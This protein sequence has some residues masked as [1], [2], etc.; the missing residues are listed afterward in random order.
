MS[1]C[2]DHETG[3]CVRP[4]QCGCALSISRKCCRKALA[5]AAAAQAGAD[6]A[7]ASA[8]RAQ[9][10][11]NFAQTAAASAQTAADAA[12]AA[13]DAAAATALIALNTSEAQLKSK[14]P[15]AS[16]LL[17][18]VISDIPSA[19]LSIP[20]SALQYASVLATCEAIRAAFDAAY[21][22]SRVLY[23]APDG[24][25][26]VDTSKVAANTFAN[27]QAKAINENHNTR[28]AVMSAQLSPSGLGAEVKFSTSTLQNEIYA[29]KFINGV[30]FNNQGT[31]RVSY[32]SA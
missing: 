4:S 32:L 14:V 13:A 6:A 15:L 17:G 25:V 10:T 27:F 5:D 29:A 31:V 2:R 22:A 19:A 9:A 23:C 1:C 3:C 21:P 8:N 30:Q 11:A 26:I 7:Q 18:S 24:T 20:G 16:S 28:V 12:Q